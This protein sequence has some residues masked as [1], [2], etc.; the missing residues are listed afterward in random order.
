LA[1]TYNLNIVGPNCLGIY[2]NGMNLT[3]GT[4]D[5]QKGQVNLFSQSGAI[6][7]ELMDKAALKKIGFEN[8]VSVGNMADVD[9][10]DLIS[11]Y[12]GNHPINLYIEGIS[13]GKNLLRAM[14]KSQ[15]QIKIFKAGKSE[16]A[17]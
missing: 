13:H 6:V 15:S 1:S 5:I 12:P 9:F 3:F 8:I 11:S 2:A 7:A 16:V 4:Q 10:G 14:R 17:Q